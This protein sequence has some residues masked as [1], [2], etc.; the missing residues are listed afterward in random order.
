MRRVL[1]LPG[2]GIGPEVTAVARAALEALDRRFGLALAFEEA[3]IGGAAI[4]ATGDPL[5]PATLAAAQASAAVFLGAVGGPRWDKGP[6]RPEEG[7][8]GLRKAL[9]VFANLR[10]VT[11]SPALAARGPLKPE[12]VAGADILIVRELTGGLYFGEK[13]EGD[14][15]ASDLCIYTRD[16]IERVAHIAFQAARRRRGKVTSVDK[17]NVLATSRLWRR[18][19]TTVQAQHYPDMALEHVL[20][21]AMAMH[22]LSPPTSFDVVLTE[23]LFGDILSDEAS[24][25]AGAIGVLGS[26]SLGEQ[27]PGLFEPIHGSAPD[28]AGQDKANPLGALASAA[29]LLRDGLG[30]MEAAAA[31]EQAIAGAIA[32]GEVTADLGGAL[33]CRA[34]GAAALR[35]LPP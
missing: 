10:P 20:V 12:I 4:D 23:N 33:G 5:P 35:R 32:A 3:L 16:E 17:A 24:M 8:L 28:I 21:D 15:Q 22:L 27:G 2:D 9:G 6:R 34:A 7:L 19:V 14:E 25:L 11:V 30:A 18:T 1:L 31:L 26:A 29:M 13:R